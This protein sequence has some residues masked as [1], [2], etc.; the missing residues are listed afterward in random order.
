MNPMSEGTVVCPHCLAPNAERSDFC[1]ECG[2]PLTSH[3]ETDPLGQI[4]ATGD[5][6][7]KAI[8]SPVK[9]IVVIGM[10]LIFG[11][12]AA[13]GV[14]LLLWFSIGIATNPFG[15]VTIQSVFGVIIFIGLS[16]GMAAICST[17]LYRTTRNYIRL[18]AK[19]LTGHVRQRHESRNS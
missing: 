13:G 2:T 11:P 14:G 7:L 16:T 17:V 1:R 19:P 5:T 12:M 18:R 3:A 4:R 10:W 15:P 9:P 8:D 6:Y